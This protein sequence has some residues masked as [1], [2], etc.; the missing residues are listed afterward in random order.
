[1]PLRAVADQLR[2]KLRRRPS[3]FL[4]GKQ[5]GIAPPSPPIT[6][7]LPSPRHVPFASKRASAHR[8]SEDTPVSPPTAA[9]DTTAAPT[10]PLKSPSRRQHGHKQPK[11]NI[12]LLQIRLFMVLV[13]IISLSR[14]DMASLAKYG[15]LDITSLVIKSL[16][17]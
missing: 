10:P 7:D 4:H 17:R 14:L 1:M 5:H 15:W 8:H 3:T 11:K 2:Y 9:V 13:I 6:E 16:S 12:L